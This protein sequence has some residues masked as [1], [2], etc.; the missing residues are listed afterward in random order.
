MEFG[1]RVGIWYTDGEKETLHNATEIHYGYKTILGL[2]VA[3]ESDIHKTG[4]N[5]IVSD[6]TEFETKTETEIAE[7]F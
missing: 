3:F 2:R 6:I 5:V 4:K 7:S 1:L